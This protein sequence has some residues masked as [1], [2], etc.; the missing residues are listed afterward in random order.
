MRVIV[1]LAQL[2]EVDLAVDAHK[3]RLAEIAEAAREPVALVE[4][5]R[6]IVRAESDLAHCRAVQTELEAVQN[7]VV[8]KLTRAE[9]RLYSGG[10]RN[11]KELEDLQLDVAQLR[12]QLSQAEDNLLE[13]LIC[14]ETA[15]QA[16]AEQ[17]ARLERLTVEHGRKHAA[18][19]TEH[20]QIKAKL[21]AELVQQAAARQAVPAP[22]LTTYD[23]LRPRRGGRAV[24]KLDGEECSAC[25]VAAS[26]F[27]LEAARFGDELVYCSNCGRLLWGE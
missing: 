26:P 11:P 27:S 21:A 12:R 14:A 9:T 24:A 7:A 15:T 16:Q 25:L 1:L 5:R 8:E 22:L 6:G 19:R 4:A 13:A 23:N 20:A 10:V 3:A 2:N 18:L 17:T